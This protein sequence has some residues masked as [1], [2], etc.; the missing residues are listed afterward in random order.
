MWAALAAAAV[1]AVAGG[2]KDH[3][4]GTSNNSNSSSLGLRYMSDLDRGRSWL[5]RD[6]DKQSLSSYKDLIN[7]TN[8]GPG[9]SEVEANNLFQN[10]FAQQLQQM[11][12]TGGGPNSQMLE[13]A[14]Q[15]SSSIFK[16]QQVALDQQ[17]EDAQ[18]DSNRLAARLGRAGNDPILR[19]KL[20]QEKTRQQT[21][22][23]AQQGAFTANYAQ[24][25][26]QQ[27]INMGSTL[28]NL[29]QGLA[30]QAFQNR[31]ALLTM[32]QQITQN[33]RNYRVN[34]AN[35]Y[36]SGFNAQEGSSGGGFKGAVSGAM[37]GAG[38]V[39]GGGGMGGGGGSNAGGGSMAG[40][41]YMNAGGMV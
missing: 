41:S 29:R 8:R 15:F 20:M 1:G 27:F 40:G 3:S 10:D 25:M 9:E 4:Q 7:L 24:Q 28:S 31:Q 18:V 33:E 6:A 30:T 39:M 36:G 17:F 21:S 32:G 22:L 2:Q 35:R 11:L 12:S 37:A 23:N 19:N 26:P 34:T 16:P 5:E 13:Q 14:N 38:A